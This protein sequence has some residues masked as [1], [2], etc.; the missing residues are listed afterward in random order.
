MPMRPEIRDVLRGLA[1][2]AASPDARGMEWTVFGSLGRGAEDPKDVDVLVDAS[3]LD[4]ASPAVERVASRL[5]DLARRRYGWLDPFLRTRFG[6][7]ARNPDASGWVRAK[8]A[9]KILFDAGAGMPLGA[10]AVAALDQRDGHEPDV[11]PPSAP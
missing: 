5:L 2:I 7:A 11:T 4:P 9:S 8:K 1:A 10:F 6:L 3:L